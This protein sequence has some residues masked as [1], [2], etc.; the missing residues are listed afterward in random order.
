MIGAIYAVLR[1][2]LQRIARYPTW[3]ANESLSTVLMIVPIVLMGLAWV[4]S[5]G[6][7]ANRMPAAVPY[8]LVGSIVWQ[9]F[10]RM[11]YEMGYALRDEMLEGTLECVFTVPV[12]YIAVLAGRAIVSGALGLLQAILIWVIGI[13]LFRFTGGPTIFPVIGTLVL[14]LVSMS[15]LT[16]AFS[17]LVL[18][19]KRPATW[20][21]LIN[22]LVPLVGGVLVPVDLLPSFA[23]PISFALPTTYASDLLRYILLGTASGMGP[24][25]DLWVLSLM[26]IVG[27]V[28]GWATFRGVYR[29]ARVSGSLLHY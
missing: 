28:V 29:S 18:K 1:R 27:P 20:V 4:G 15:G 13:A 19:M 22:A 24:Q 3:I 17:A 23:R 14:F 9:L 26:A 8:M 12:P 6:S 10:G 7:W 21:N 16:I 5:A 2:E 25:L 11:I